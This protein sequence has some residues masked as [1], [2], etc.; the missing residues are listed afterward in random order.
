MFFLLLWFAEGRMIDC[1]DQFSVEAENWKIMLL[2]FT[3][4]SYNHRCR[5]KQPPPA[6]VSVETLSLLKLSLLLGPFFRL[7]L[8]LLLLFDKGPLAGQQLLGQLIRLDL[9]VRSRLLRL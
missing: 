2:R 6:T 8:L 4:G 1:R 7:F 9:L 3:F 5:V